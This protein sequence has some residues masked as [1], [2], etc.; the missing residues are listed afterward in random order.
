[1][2]AER[3]CDDI[4]YL[5]IPTTGLFPLGWDAGFTMMELYL[6]GGG[7]M[8]YRF[9][10]CYDVPTYVEDYFFRP[11]WNPMHCRSCRL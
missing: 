3:Q 6:G 7:P 8:T 11:I 9:T 1:M 2:R 5:L 10:L 4:N